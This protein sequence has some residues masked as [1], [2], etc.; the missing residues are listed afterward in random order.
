[1]RFLVD[2]AL[3][4]LIARQLRDNGHDATHLRDLGLQAAPD[5]VVF[6]LAAAEDRILISADTDF[7]ALLARRSL[8]KP[9][10]I[11]FRGEITRNPKIQAATLLANLPA[12]EDAVLAGSIVVFEEARVRIRNLP[13]TGS[14]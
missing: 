14:S 2:N 11:L 6:D 7:G 3:S 8:T 5:E 13:L 12:I 4:P 1:M 10:V 9:S